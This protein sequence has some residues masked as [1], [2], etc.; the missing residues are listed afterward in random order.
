[1]CFGK[2]LMVL[3]GPG[4]G[5]TRVITEKLIHC[6]EHLGFAPD[7]VLALTF[8]RK[9]AE[10][11]L[12]RVQNRIPEHQGGFVVSTTHAFCAEIVR[13]EHAFLGVR[14]GFRIVDK[15]QALLIA[16]SLLP[17]FTRKRLI[18]VQ[19][20]DESLSEML[21]FISKA[22]D[23][24]AGIEELE[25]YIAQKRKDVVNDE[26]ARVQVELI[27]E[28]KD[29]WI[30]LQN[31]YQKQNVLDFGDLIREA[32]RVL[33]ENSQIRLKWQKRYRY[34][35]VDEFQDSNYAQIELVRLLSDG[36]NICVVGDDDQSIYRFRG[37]SYAAFKYFKNLFPDVHE[38][39]LETSYRFTP[40]IL[41]AAQ[42]VIRCNGRNRYNP[43]KA[44][45]CVEEGGGPVVLIKNAGF[46]AEAHEVASFIRASVAVEGGAYSD[47]AVLYR[48]HTHSE[49]LMEAL[50]AQNIPFVV[51]GKDS[52][53]DYDEIRELVFYMRFL[54][55]PEDSRYLFRLFES[56]FLSL[57]CDEVAV[58]DDLARSERDRERRRVTY[59]DLVRRY[60]EKEPENETA[61]KL[62]RF[63]TDAVYFQKMLKYEPAHFVL[64]DILNRTGFLKALIA[65]KASDAGFAL[66]RINRLCAVVTMFCS[67][68]KDKNLLYDFLDM[69]DSRAITG[70]ALPAGERAGEEM[71]NKEGVRLMTVHAAKGLEFPNVAVISLVGRR[72]P[73]QPKSERMP[74]PDEL[75]REEI[76]EGDVLLQEERRLFYVAITRAKKRLILSTVDKKGVAPSV[77]VKQDLKEMAS[78][79]DVRDMRGSEAAVSDASAVGAP[80]PQWASEISR[81]LGRFF[82]AASAADLEEGY[83]E[84]QRALSRYLKASEFGQDLF[85]RIPENW[86]VSAG[87]E[88]VKILSQ[89]GLE[90]RTKRP[91][92]APSYISF[93]QIEMYQTCPLKYKFGY[94][95]HIP[96][97]PSGVLAFGSIMHRTLE[98]F[99]S[100]L[101]AGRDPSLDRLLEIYSEK[102]EGLDFRDALEE[103]QRRREGREQLIAY[104]KS[105][106]GR[107]T[108][109]LA[110]EKPFRFK[111][112]SATISGVMDR[113]D[114]IDEGKRAVEIVDYKTGKPK[115]QKE[116]DQ[117]LQMSIYAIACLED[118]G[119]VPERL[120]FYYLTSQDK[121]STARNDVQLRETKEKIRGVMERIQE[122]MFDSTPGF[123]CRFCQFRPICDDAQM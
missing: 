1:M 7:E 44:L 46:E 26:V 10:E 113:I 77:F 11:M 23:E 32:V 86:R 99:Y 121:V 39:S 71:L 84:I 49:K 65:D 48:A 117:S 108:K 119:L 33:R 21:D 88:D 66:E 30:V 92:T 42:A 105:Q 4:S 87:S 25:T 81:G 34:I 89:K 9:A 109:P 15:L 112:G 54:A 115:D 59:F 61:R 13:E 53:F 83:V 91:G 14:S 36:T 79:F 96:A 120:S 101:M 107:W 43:D 60:C 58:L 94:L 63:L 37:A 12:E 114:A 5:K 56:R 29:N 45:R 98:A 38:I 82:S 118:L 78:R 69:L 95:Y 111:I 35:L 16:R 93:T 6:V 62:K 8:S 27:E 110:V 47:W 64:F 73:S 102:W 85:G 106:E 123:H 116:A 103:D 57:R 80:Y 22:K 40:A 74:F 76:P 52:L 72:F 24:G 2:P 97:P 90:L 50:T 3:A 104:V 18:Q 100:E 55:D 28:I 51:L 19:A 20:P 41:E 31:E 68:N 17:A 75:C 122:G 70:A 67:E